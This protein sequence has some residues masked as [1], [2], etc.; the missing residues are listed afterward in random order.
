MNCYRLSVDKSKIKTSEGTSYILLSF[1]FKG[2]LYQG[3]TVPR[4]KKLICF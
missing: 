1:Y 4:E 2:E 3:L